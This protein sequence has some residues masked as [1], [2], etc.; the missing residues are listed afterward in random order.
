M[1][2]DRLASV[3]ALGVDLISMGALTHSVV[4]ADVSMRFQWNSDG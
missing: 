4:S 3:A 1:T 2:A